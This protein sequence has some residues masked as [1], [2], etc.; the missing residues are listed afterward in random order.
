ML[1]AA[2]GFSQSPNWVWAKSNS[3]DPYTDA[4]TSICTDANGNSYI[5][6]SFFGPAVTFG[7]FTLTNAN[8]NWADIYIVKYDPSG[9]VLWAKSA[10]GIHDDEGLSIV[11][12]T[13]GYIYLTGY[14]ESSTITFGGTT[15]TNNDTTGCS[16]DIFL[17]KYDS[18]GNVVWAKSAGGNAHEVGRSV[19]VD[20]K[21]NAYISGFY[22]S[23]TF[24]FGSDTLVGYFNFPKILVVKYDSIGNACW[25]RSA[26]GDYVDQSTSISTDAAGNAY[27]T[28][29]FGSSALD[30]G[31]DTLYNNYASNIFIVKY[32]SLGNVLWAKCSEEVSNNQSYGWGITADASG[33]VYVTGEASAVP[34]T[35]DTITLNS[36]GAFIVKYNSIGNVVWAKSIIGGSFDSDWYNCNICLDLLGNF[37]IVG[38][39]YSTITIGGTTLTNTGMADIFVAKYDINGNAL[40]AQKA[41]GLGSEEGAAIGVDAIGNTYVTGSFDTTSFFGTIVLPYTYSPTAK[42]DIFVAKL[43]YKVGI[44]EFTT[45]LDGM[46]VFPNP[47]TD[48]ITIETPQK[49]EIEILNIQ[50]QIIKT[51]KSDG[52][53]TTI[54][55]RNLSSG[56]YIIKAKTERGVAVKKFIKE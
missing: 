11:M 41:G 12:D 36:N 6:G 37:Y 29:F 19:S 3:G 31:T 46:M 25:A 15:L 8:F 49:S 13:K 35:F 30:F 26:I 54:D 51:A 33:N 24:V 10:G 4:G 50:G 32:D 43:D 45:S 39:F 21:G 17:V 53:E 47:A 22:Q 40:W 48:N 42:F 16:G 18:T 7:A 34:I 56:V 14:F 27:V 20:I 2:F 52:K 28:G 38:E 55:L 5:T 44:E 1:I 23:P 9:N